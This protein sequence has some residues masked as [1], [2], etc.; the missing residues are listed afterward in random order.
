[1][2]A[3]E[4]LE[5]KF[6]DQIQYKQT[7]IRPEFPGEIVYQRILDSEEFVQKFHDC[8]IEMVI[9]K[10]PATIQK[11]NDFFHNL[12]IKT[13]P[14]NWEQEHYN[15]LL[16]ELFLHAAAI[17]LRARQY[18]LLD[19]ILSEKRSYNKG[20]RKRIDVSF[21]HFGLPCYSLEN[22]QEESRRV[23][24]AQLI[25]E[26]SL[27]VWKS[28]IVE[29]DLVL[30]YLSCLRGERRHPWTPTLAGYHEEGELCFLSLL[31]LKDVYLNAQTLLGGYS[32]EDLSLKAKEFVLPTGHH[33]FAK[34]DYAPK[35]WEVMNIENIATL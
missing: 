22:K 11:L 23:T 24:A 10:N 12:Q 26:R 6:F 34:G 9:E 15:F 13:S 21:V 7:S 35:L 28:Q 19:G 27:N 2:K 29:T 1:M 18:H 31:K 16:R 3:F 4:R 5:K 33:P 25:L 20:S 14:Y 32:P 8:L 17:L 30:F